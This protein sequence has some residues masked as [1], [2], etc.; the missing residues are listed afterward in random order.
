MFAIQLLQEGGAQTNITWLVWVVLVLFFVMVFLGWLVSSKG[1]LED[2][3]QPEQDA[4][5]D[6]HK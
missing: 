5:A 6:H 1:W 3:S 2:E 4:H